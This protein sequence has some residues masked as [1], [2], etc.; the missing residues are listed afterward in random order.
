M[1]ILKKKIADALGEVSSLTIAQRQEAFNMVEQ[2]L[3]WKPEKMCYPKIEFFFGFLLHINNYE[4]I[5]NLLSSPV[6]QLYSTQM[7]QPAPWVNPPQ[8][9]Q[10]A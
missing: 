9:A 3:T 1:G 2:F 4:L 10:A 8:I 5:K 6:K 7:M